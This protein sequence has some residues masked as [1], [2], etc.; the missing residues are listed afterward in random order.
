MIVSTIKQFGLRLRADP[1][2][3]PFQ[4]SANVQM[5]FIRAPD[6]VDYKVMGFYQAPGDPDASKLDIDDEGIFN[7]G[8]RVFKRRGTLCISFAL[9]RGDTIIHLDTIEFEVRYSF[10]DGDTIL[11]EP[12]EVWITLVTQVAKDAIREEVALVN[13][14]ASEAS[15]SAN[16]ASEKANEAKEYANNANQSANSASSAA[17]SA[18]T[19][20][21]DAIAASNSAIQAKQDAEQSANNA[22]NSADEALENA[23]ASN[24]AIETV[25]QIKTQIEDK[26]NEFDTNYQEKLSAF[27]ENATEKQ[28]KFN[29][30]SK[31]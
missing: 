7:L 11:P 18:L 10:G 24:K 6:Y 17:S 13:Q 29:T 4:H 22:K 12:E 8:A 26:A 3:I 31:D 16:L 5:K 19:A 15:S 2:E 25:N 1:E 14:K 30:N 28:N 20:K 9:Y 27:N 23:N 21:N